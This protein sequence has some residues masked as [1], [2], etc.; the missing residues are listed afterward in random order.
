MTDKIINGASNN[1][2]SDNASAQKTLKVALVGIGGMGFCHYCCYD[3]V[4]NA[5]IVAVC[6]VRADMAKQK[7]ADRAKAQNTAG[8]ADLPRVYADIDEM[9]A[10]EKI[11][12]ADICT[13]SYMHA[14]L[15]VKCLE[16]GINVLCEK[17][18]TLNAADAERVLAAADKSGKKFMAAHVVRYMAPYVYLRKA[19]ESKKLGE[20]IRLDMK[21][22]SAIPRWSWQDWMRD[23]SLS[24]GVGMD[25]SVHDLDFVFS[26][27]GKPEKSEA[28]YRPIKNN[29]SYIISTL[30]YKN[31]T[32]TCEGAWYNF[33]DFAFRSDFLAVF[34]NG[35][36]RSEGGVLTENGKAVEL[37][38]G[39][40]S[41]KT[42]LG[43][44]ISGDD[45]YSD[46]I[47]YFV[48]CVIND[49]PVTYVAPE[50]S[51]QTVT[52]TENLVK[53]AKIV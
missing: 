40:E 34:D 23:E 43:I 2:A 20:L 3:N 7:I 21:R 46:E 31:A 39:D 5:K 38:G 19:I 26:V 49:L 47:A 52:L 36:I 4:K 53:N 18:M 14:D 37:G 35:Y 13:P 28:V 42:D 1:G 30:G 22:L 32:V 12:V 44:N 29:S 24:G 25:L 6:D 8:E 51:A 9:L 11:D 33:E 50:S 48:N 41:V 17:P 45:A 27:L 15:S 10:K 16:K